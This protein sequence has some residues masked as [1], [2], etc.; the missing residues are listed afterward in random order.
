M[1]NIY[2]LFSKN[3]DDI[4]ADDL[5]ILKDIN[6]GWFVEYKEDIPKPDAIAKYMTSFA[7]T[8]GGWIFF[9]IAE[10]SK[11]NP[12]AGSFPG[13][14]R[15]DAEKLLQTIR[16]VAANNCEPVPFFNKKAVW[17]PCESIGLCKDKCVIILQVP[18]GGHAPY[19]HKDGRIYRRVGDG[20]EPKPETDRFLLE[21]LF[22]R[23]QEIRN[24]HRDNIR[25]SLQQISFDEHNA[26]MKIFF[27]S[28]FWMEREVWRFL[29][30]HDI[31]RILGKLSDFY[32]ID[33]DTIHRNVNGFTCRQ[34]GNNDPAKNVM[35]W[36]ASHNLD[37]EF[38]LPIRKIFIEDVSSVP[39]H[40]NEYKYGKRFMDICRKRNFKE[41]MI[42]D[43][44]LLLPALMAISQILV[45]FNQEFNT[46]E[47]VHIKICMTGVKRTVPFLDVSYALDQF[48]NLGVPMVLDD[49]L[50]IFPGSTP[51]SYLE[52]KIPKYGGIENKQTELATKL[53]VNVMMALGF[54]LRS[55]PQDERSGTDQYVLELQK[56]GLRAS[57]IWRGDDDVEDF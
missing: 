5:V 32:R 10:H 9:G 57:R 36:K 48:Q 51:D 18:Q 4:D 15:G 16:N 20:S 45:I 52:E 35:M 34:V 43:L 3:F 12:V 44:N 49:E 17:G 28:D 27:I 25:A 33:F 2:K 47:S 1:E 38:T 41:L 46:H 31:K 37:N 30:I 8:Y 29:E 14:K 23:S 6:E 19:I 24:S 54:S 22:L 7:N 56:A 11:E 21:K 55:D 40:I 42:L 39:E 53:F 26:Y 13:I 50:V